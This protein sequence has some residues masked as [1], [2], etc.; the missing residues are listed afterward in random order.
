MKAI[1]LAGCLALLLAV[2]LTLPGQAQSGDQLV[3]MQTTKGP[4]SMRILSSIVPY[5][6]GNFL[7]LVSKGFYDGLSFH[8]VE[9]WCVQGGDPNGNGTGNYVDP[10]TGQTKFKC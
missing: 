7:D 10:A 9:N 6:A 2:G 3:V 5:T 1:A 4:I 8:R